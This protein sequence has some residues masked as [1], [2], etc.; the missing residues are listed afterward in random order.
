VS[1][2][3]AQNP[4]PEQDT[5][6]R[7]LWELPAFRDVLAADAEEADEDAEDED[8]AP[9]E[10]PYVVPADRRVPRREI[11]MTPRP[12]LARLAV[13]RIGGVPIAPSVD[14]PWPASHSRPMQLVL[15]LMGSDVPMGDIKVLQ[16]FADLEGEFYDD[17]VVVMHRVDCPVVLEPPV[18]T[19]TQPCK[20][21]TFHAG[22]DDAI[23]RDDE[24]DAEGAYSH[25]FC[26]KI[27]GI[28]VGANMDPEEYDAQ[29]QLMQ[30]LVQLVT[31]DDWFLWYLFANADFSE[32]RMQ[33]VRG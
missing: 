24:A 25:A 29:G 15:Q 9:D 22:D 26:D 6:L 28:P 12:D 21:M 10:E 16:V 27:G 13:S 4:H 5:D 1:D 20:V 2:L 23:L 33:I 14:T 18:G 7:T 3:R 31:Y 32:A 17:N 30:C 19:A 11:R 8:A